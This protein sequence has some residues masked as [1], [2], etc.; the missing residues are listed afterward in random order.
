M[1][2]LLAVIYCVTLLTSCSSVPY[3]SSKNTT[4]KI[5][6][7]RIDLNNTNKVKQ[8]LNKQYNDW[9]NVPHRMGGLSKSGVDCS[10]LVYITYREKFGIDVPRST[11][12]QS[13]VGQSIKKHQLRAGDMV[14]FKTGVKV[15]HV[16]IY[17][18]KGDFIHASSSKGVMISNLD[19]PYWSSAYWKAQRLQ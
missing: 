5:A 1:Y 19:N 13:Q 4:V 14:F 8:T 9:H 3:Q 12:Y 15:R 6:S 2:K 18:D 7:Q 10:G 17:I 16:G 11:E